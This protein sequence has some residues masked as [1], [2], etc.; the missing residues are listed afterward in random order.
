M[1]ISER[2]GGNIPPHIKLDEIEVSNWAVFVAALGIPFLWKSV[3]Q[4]F[5]EKVAWASAWIFALFQSDPAQRVESATE[6]PHF[7][8]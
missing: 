8:V 3:S 6:V 2:R 5:G 1:T 7:K 4:V